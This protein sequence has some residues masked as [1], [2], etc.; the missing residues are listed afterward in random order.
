MDDHIT[1]GMFDHVDGSMWIVTNKGINIFKGG[2]WSTINKKT[3]LMKNKIGSYMVDSQD[4]VWVGTGTPDIFFDGYVLGE[5]Y[6]GGIMIYDGEKWEP[7]NTTD[8]GIK[9]PV[10]TRMYQATNGDIWLGVSAVTPG[11]ERGGLFAK[12]ALVRYFDGQWKVYKGNDVPCVDCHF[13]KGF[14][15]DDNGKMFFFA[16]FGVFYFEN[17]LFHS[18]KKDNE[19]FK[20]SRGDYITSRFKDS[21]NNLWLGTPGRIAKYDHKTWRSFNRKNGLPSMDSPPYGFVETP[22]GKIMMTLM[23]WGFVCRAAI[24]IY[25]DLHPACIQQ[26]SFDR[27]GLEY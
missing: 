17:G 25:Y 13:V 9:T 10:I 21:Q 27:H 16:D 12:G 8:M 22:D 19:E 4:R 7:M 15:E 18:V 11:A 5:L 14:Y 2:E 24:R 6:D 1:M 23:V 3:D 26:D 20:F